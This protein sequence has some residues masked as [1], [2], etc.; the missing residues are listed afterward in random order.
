MQ[1]IICMIGAEEEEK[2]LEIA[3]KDKVTAMA[4]DNNATH[5]L[6][7]IIACLAEEKLDYIFYPLIED[8][9]P[10]SLD[11]NGLCVIKKVI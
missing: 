8:F 6:Q 5:V 11:A 7:K 10:L 3:V 9:M 4:L 2:L 1:T